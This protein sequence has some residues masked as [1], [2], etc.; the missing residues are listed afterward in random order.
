[1]QSLQDQVA[2]VTGGALGIGGATAR[3]LAAGGAKVLIADFNPAAA[4]A[5][6]AHIQAAGGVSSGVSKSASPNSRRRRR[7]LWK[8]CCLVCIVG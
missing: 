2:I 6:V 8:K 3:R 7:L 4:Q 1:M 5:N